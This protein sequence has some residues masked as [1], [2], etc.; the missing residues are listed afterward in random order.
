[1]DTGKTMTSLLLDYPTSIQSFSKGSIIF[2]YWGLKTQ[3]STTCIT[4]PAFLLLV[5]LFFFFSDRILWFFSISSVAKI[6]GVHRYAWLKESFCQPWHVEKREE[7]VLPVLPALDWGKN[8]GFGVSSRQ[9]HT[10]QRG[11]AFE[12]CCAEL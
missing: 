3:G 1:M 2:W 7:K 11:G 5:C 8:M 12:M 9:H 10:G 6:I 4:L